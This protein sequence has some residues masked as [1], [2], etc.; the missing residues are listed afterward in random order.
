[1]TRRHA[2]H[3]GLSFA[4][5][6]IAGCAVSTP[7]TRLN[8]TKNIFNSAL[9]R[10]AGRLSLVIDS[11]NSPADTAQSFSGSFELRGNANA[12]ALD[13]LSPLGQIVMQLRWQSGM[14]QLVRGNEIQQFDSAQ[15]LLERATGASLTLDTLFAWLQGQ[16][17]A[18]QAALPK[19]KPLGD[20]L[21]D[22]SGHAQGRIVARRT[23]PTP[24]VLRIVLE[25]S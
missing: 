17:S 22:L 12:G 14:A 10:Y 19:D 9:Q 13:L 23:L 2:I 18:A 4:I 6:S 11:A 25:S 8:D 3:A 7:A 15:S 21:V 1:M 16:P 5:I 20:W 24:A